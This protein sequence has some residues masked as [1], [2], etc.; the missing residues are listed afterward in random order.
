ME[1]TIKVK[2]LNKKYEGFELKNISFD[3]ID[4]PKQ[5]RKPEQVV[6]F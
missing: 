3:L 1:A 2:N 6:L 5:Q 4:G